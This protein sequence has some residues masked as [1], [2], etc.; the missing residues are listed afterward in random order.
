MTLC[1]PTHTGRMVD[2]LDLRPWDVHPADLGPALGSIARWGGQADQ[3]YS[4]AQHCLHVSALV[5]HLGPTVAL[6]GL[7]HD[8]AEAYLGDVSSPLKRRLMVAGPRG[9]EDFRQAEARTLAAILARVNL[10]SELPAEVK[11]ADRRAQATEARDLFKPS[12]VL[13]ELLEP[14]PEAIVPIN[15][16]VAANE[17]LRRLAELVSALQDPSLDTTVEAAMDELHVRSIC[18]ADQT[19]CLSLV[20]A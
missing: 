6:A 19:P 13:P 8:G 17:W 1:I 11:L 5:D 16:Q 4:V 3:F 15:G 9:L 18:R 12:L 2:P 20:G 14:L 10:P 7:L